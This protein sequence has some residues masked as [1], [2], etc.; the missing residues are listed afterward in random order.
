MPDKAVSTKLDTVLAAE[1]CDFVGIFPVVLALLR[2]S[3]LRFHRIFSGDAVELPLNEGNLCRVGHVVDVDGHTYLE[4][5]LVGIFETVCNRLLGA[6]SRLGRYKCTGSKCK[7]ANS[8][9]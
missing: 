5:I 9:F 2:L 4:I 6:S 1:I 8:G 3:W 7:C